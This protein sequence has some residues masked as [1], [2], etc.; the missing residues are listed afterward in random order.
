LRAP[1]LDLC[2][3]IS[4][5]R[6]FVIQ[7]FI[8]ITKFQSQVSTSLQAKMA[9]QGKERRVGAQEGFA[10]LSVKLVLLANGNRY[11]VDSNT[12]FFLW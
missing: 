1:T 3:T 5:S 9:P 4:K 10:F 2:L 6:K 7:G 8:R 11:E 12:F